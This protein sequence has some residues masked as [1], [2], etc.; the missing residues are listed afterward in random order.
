MRFKF[1]INDYFK[2]FVVC[3]VIFKFEEVLGWLYIRMNKLV[4]EYYYGIIFENL[5]Y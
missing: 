4:D 1:L 5:I 2:V 3:D